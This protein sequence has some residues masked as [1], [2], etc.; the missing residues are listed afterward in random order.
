[1]QIGLSLIKLGFLEMAHY[2]R[3][4]RRFAAVQSYRSSEF[5]EFRV[6]GVQSFRSSE[7]QEFS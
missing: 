7:F 1:M 6:S 2:V 3:L 5:Q 4:L